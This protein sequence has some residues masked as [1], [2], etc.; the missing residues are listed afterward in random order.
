MKFFQEPAD[1]LIL[2]LRELGLLRAYWLP[3]SAAS[4]CM[5]SVDKFGAWHTHTTVQNN[6]V[7][8]SIVRAVHGEG[9]FYA[10]I[11]FLLGLLLGGLAMRFSATGRGRDRT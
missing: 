9:R 8:R 10:L 3:Q 11:L 6:S 4:Q 5:D 7:L 2:T 1:G